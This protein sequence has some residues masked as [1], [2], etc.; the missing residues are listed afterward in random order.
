VLQAYAE[1]GIYIAVEGVPRS[2][3]I[4]IEKMQEYMRIRPNGTPTWR[5][6]RNCVN[7]IRELKKLRWATYSS[8]KQAYSM[9]K[10]E[11]IHKKDDHAADSM[12]YFM[13]LMPDLRPNNGRELTP[14]EKTPTTIP[15]MDLLAKMANDPNVTFVDELDD[16]T[17]WETHESSDEYYGGY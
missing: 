2:V 6:T 11:E 9:N 7:L 1:N 13:T 8:D 5:V 17:Q 4:G 10:Q 14:N 3:M 16:R 12:R 15:Y